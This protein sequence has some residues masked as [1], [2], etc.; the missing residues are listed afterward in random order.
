MSPPGSGEG[1]GPGAAPP[2]GGGAGAM[3]ERERCMSSYCVHLAYTHLFGSRNNP[4][5]LGELYY[6]FR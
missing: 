1:G 2:P 4:C 6:V 3:T 5:E